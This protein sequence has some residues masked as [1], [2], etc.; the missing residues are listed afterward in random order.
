MAK[1]D[2][3]GSFT[4]TLTGVTASDDGFQLRVQM[5]AGANV[6]GGEYFGILF[7]TDPVTSAKVFA[8]MVHGIAT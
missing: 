2:G 5:K 4:M 3:T 8:T 7:Y 1:V 6:P